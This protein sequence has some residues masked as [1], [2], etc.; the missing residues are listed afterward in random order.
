[1][2]PA[3]AAPRRD[4]DALRAELV[5]ICRRAHDRSFI[6][7]ADGNVSCRLGDDL[8]VT[9]SG[10]NKGHLRPID[11]VRCDAE[12]RPRRGQGR[13]SGELALHLASYRLRPEIQAVV[14]AHPPHAIA[15]SLAG[16]SLAHTLMPEVVFALGATGI[17]TVP[18]ATPVTEDL[19]RACEPWLRAFN[20]MILERHGTLTLGR[21]LE[22]AYNRL[23][24]LEHTARITAIA[25][26]V[27]AATPLPT[28]EVERIIALAGGIGPRRT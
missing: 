28:G 12:G 8:L 19:P 6:Q 3:P 15:L 2:P 27:G 7:S 24:A 5:E 22:E 4:E 23:E 21:T 25:R 20:A 14:H 26:S 9:P 13:P 1:M 17:P 18:Y 11:L 10:A 16:I